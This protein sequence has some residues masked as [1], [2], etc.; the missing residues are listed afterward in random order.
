MI[1]GAALQLWKQYSLT[2]P[3]ST[4]WIRPLPRVPRMT[5]AGF[6]RSASR[7]ITFPTSPSTIRAL[8]RTNK[9]LNASIAR[10]SISS[11]L[12]SY[13][14]SLCTSTQI[15]RHIEPELQ[16]TANLTY[17]PALCSSDAWLI[18]LKKMQNMRKH[19]RFVRSVLTALYYPDLSDHQYVTSPIILN[20]Y[21]ETNII[22]PVNM[23]DQTQT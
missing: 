13:R 23:S 19:L 15:K 20:I 7:H 14:I 8:V 5:A 3:C 11:R 2:L 22:G 4:L 10:S 1:I 9:V 17:S 12:L 18:F 21:S 16:L 6:S